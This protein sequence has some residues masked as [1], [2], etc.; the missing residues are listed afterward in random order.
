MT[1]S[2][3]A[4]LLAAAPVGL[5][6]VDEIGT[7][8]YATPSV[9]DLTGYG[10]TE[11]VGTNILSYLPDWAVQDLLS[12][13]EYVQEYTDAVMGPA[14]IA[15]I[16]AD[17]ELRVLEIYA[18]NRLADPDIAGLVVAVRDQTFQ[19]RINEA[20]QAYTEGGGSQAALDVLCA[21]LLGLPI[22]G[23]AALV[24]AATGTRL[25]GFEL[26]EVLTAAAPA[27]SPPRPWQQA[28]ASGEV[29]APPDLADADEELQAAARVAGLQTVWAVPV[30]PPG[31]QGADSVTACLVIARP[32]VDHISLNQGYVLA[33]AA[34]TAGLLLE[35]EDLV[36]RL[37]RAARTDALTGLGNR[38]ELFRDRPPRAEG[39]AGLGALAVLYLDL[40]GFKPVND[41]LGHAAGDAVLAEV[42]DRLQRV[43]RSGDELGRIGGDEFVMLCWDVA[44]DAAAIAIADRALVALE[45]PIEVPTVDGTGIETVVVGASIGI[46]RSTG[47]AA[48]SGTGDPASDDPAGSEPLDAVLHRADQA[49]YEAK[50]AGR[51]RWH[52]AR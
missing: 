41:A 10:F 21:A 48:G 50:R 8:S 30:S 11:V 24:D 9:Y 5:L 17:G 13:V 33:N 2:F 39:P 51:N 35:R 18:S 43:R 31:R 27:G 36:D 20:L 15:F 25:A 45:A 3:D 16:H 29:V 47:V 12:S 38:A 28:V 26:P 22:R 46:A 52:V 40:D 7:I 1:A 32:D 42:A 4:A 44:D 23:R 6:V 37:N 34:R 49:L 14:S 19:Y